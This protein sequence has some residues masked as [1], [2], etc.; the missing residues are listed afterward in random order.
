MDTLVLLYFA[1]SSFLCRFRVESVM[2]RFLH[3]QHFLHQQTI[4]HMRKHFPE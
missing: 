4:L 3:I 2:F 1:E